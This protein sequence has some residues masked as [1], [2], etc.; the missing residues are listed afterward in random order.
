MATSGG[1][2]GSRGRIA[3]SGGGP[4][5]V[6]WTPWVRPRSSVLP[7]SGTKATGRTCRV[8]DG[9]VVALLHQHQVLG[10]KRRADGDHH[11]AAGLQLPDERRRDVARRRGHHDRVERAA[12]LPPVVAVARPSSARW[13]S[14]ARAAA[15]P[16][17]ARAARRSR[18]C[19]PSARARRGSR[20]GSRSRCR[21]R[22]RRASRLQVHEIGHQRDDVR[23]RDGLAVADRQRAVAVGGV[24]LVR[25][26][27]SDAAARRPAPPS[28]AD[29]RRAARS[30]PRCRAPHLRCRPS[31]PCAAPRTRPRRPS[32]A[33]R[34]RGSRAGRA[35]GRGC[36]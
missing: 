31:A 20:P 15:L 22:A 26:A 16:P 27:R 18:S 28:R 2:A 29:R 11:P 4:A 3:G 7:V 24:H 19:T 10:E 35:G 14:P 33:A 5:A 8:E 30:R 1:T 23:L 25:R 9:P 36:A 17:R 34:R 21:S 32:P 12:V 6:R 13:R